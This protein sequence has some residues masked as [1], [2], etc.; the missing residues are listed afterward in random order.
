[1][2]AASSAECSSAAASRSR[3]ASSKAGTACSGSLASRSRRASA[4][5]ALSPSSC[6]RRSTSCTSNAASPTTRLQGRATGRPG[7]PAS[8]TCPTATPSAATDADRLP[9]GA[10][11]RRRPSASPPSSAAGSSG[12]EQSRAEAAR[13]SAASA[14]LSVIPAEPFEADGDV[15]FRAGAAPSAGARPRRPAPASPAPPSGKPVSEHSS[16]DPSLRSSGAV[17]RT[18]QSDSARAA[19]G[20]WATPSTAER[21]PV[22][23][24]AASEARADGS[25]WVRRAALTAAIAP[26]LVARAESCPAAL[27]AA[28]AEAAAADDRAVR[29]IHLRRVP[30]T[31]GAPPLAEPG[32][33][34]NGER[35]AA[36][37]AKRAAR[38]ELEGRSAA[39]SDASFSNKVASSAARSGRKRRSTSGT[40]HEAGREKAKTPISCCRRRS[41]SRPGL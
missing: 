22:W 33:A 5:L 4:S 30:S 13:R 27:A 20:V 9:G 19:R 3:S 31:E 25:R 10:R 29:S 1:M 32:Q 23:A 16:R 8:P 38:R 40:P 7:Q 17:S 2:R 24:S 41:T 28:V 39:A 14:G 6:L 18:V 36:A 11:R 34:S 12:K 37:P 26:S 35:S 21:V 15:R